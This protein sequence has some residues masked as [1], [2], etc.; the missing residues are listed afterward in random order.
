LRRGNGFVF[1]F[2]WGNVGEFG[3]KPFETVEIFDGAAVEALGLGLVAEE[4][5]PGGGV[6]GEAGEALGEAEVAI[7]AAG[8][9]ERVSEDFG[10]ELAHGES[11]GVHDF[12]EA[13]GEEAVFEGGAAEQ[14]LLG[15]GD[16]FDGEEFLGVE[17]LV[18]GHGV[19]PEVGDDVDFF[20]PDDG[21]VFGG[22][23]VLASVLGRAGFT[24]GSARSG[25]LCGVGAVGSV[26]V[27]LGHGGFLAFR[28]STGVVL[29][30][31][32]GGGGR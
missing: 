22:E 13:D 17:G 20:E 25:G 16:A 30:W 23:G 6:S 5:G 4:N 29:G 31:E 14:G 21:E 9:L 32:D 24:F 12:I 2:V 10:E 3:A 8:D 26:T 19:S 27:G 1:G 11:F 15:E 18:E 28:V 7:L